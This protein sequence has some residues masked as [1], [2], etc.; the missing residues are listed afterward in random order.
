MH[1]QECRASKIYESVKKFP[2]KL[3]VEEISTEDSLNDKISL[4]R[5]MHI[6]D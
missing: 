5:A 3:V 2:F 4:G 6:E 1:L